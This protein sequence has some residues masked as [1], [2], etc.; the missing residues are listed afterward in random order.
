MLRD[1]ELF[2]E[3]DTFR[4]ERFLTSN[5]NEDDLS[6]RMRDFTLPFGFGRRQCPGMH[7]ASQSIFIVLARCAHIYK[8]IPIFV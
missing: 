7:V 6:S 5:V 1:P 3:P 4:P 8:S 2:P